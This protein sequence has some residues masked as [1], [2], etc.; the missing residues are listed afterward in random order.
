MSQL[1][2]NL[3]V[4][5]F[6]K[7]KKYIKEEPSSM[8]ND[9]KSI[10]IVNNKSTQSNIN[11]QD[12]N[13]T[14]ANSPKPNIRLHE[15]KESLKMKKKPSQTSNSEL[16]IIEE[17]ATEH[18]ND[19]TIKSL[20]KVKIE[21]TQSNPIR[22]SEKSEAYKKYT[23]SSTVEYP[24]SPLKYDKKSNNNQ[25]N[26]SENAVEKDEKR[27]TTGVDIRCSRVDNEDLIPEDK[28]VFDKVIT[29]VST[30]KK[31]KYL[32]IYII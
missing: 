26:R 14:V 29:K 18:L 32:Y 27:K 10:D 20:K 13:S 28:E 3:K 1:V 4:E 12:S 30:T 23:E 22:P 2:N 24:E 17:K 15:K 11:K 6:E 7:N 8:I 16:K 31:S 21:E 19:S 5:K 25:E 9:L